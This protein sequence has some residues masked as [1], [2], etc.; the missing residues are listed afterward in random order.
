MKTVLEWL[1]AKIKT[2]EAAF[3]ITQTLLRQAFI[4][5]QGCLETVF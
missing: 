3:N 1:S 4:P 2:E 5:P